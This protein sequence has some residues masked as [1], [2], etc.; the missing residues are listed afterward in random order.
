MFSVFVRQFNPDFFKIFLTDPVGQALIV[1]A[2]VLWL[3]GIYL[4]F[5]LSK[6]KL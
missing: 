1:A 5:R 4:M 6:V 2:V 3:V